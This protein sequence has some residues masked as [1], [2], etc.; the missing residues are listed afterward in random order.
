MPILGAGVG[1]GLVFGYTSAAASATAGQSTYQVVLVPQYLSA[2]LSAVT[3]PTAAPWNGSTGGILALDVA[4]TLTLNSATVSV[5]GMGFRGGAGMQLTGAAGAANTDYLFASPAAYTG[6]AGGVAGVDGSKG[7]GVAGTPEWVESSNTFLQTIAGVGY[8]S[9]TAGTDGSMAHG[10]PGNAGGGGTDSNPAANDQNAGGGGGG[11]GG[12]GGFGGDSWNMNLS[13]G[14]EGGS[15]F[16]GTIDRIALGGGGGAGSRNNSDS[17]NQASSG[18]AGGGMVFIRAFS[19][20]GTATITANG[21]NAYNATANDAGGGGGAGGTII[22][23]AASGGE[24]GLTLQAKGGTGGNAWATQPYSLADRHG[25]GGGGGGGVIF[26]SGAPASSSV[27]G[28]ADGLTLNPG[29]AYGATSGTAGTSATTANMS[30]VTG[31]QSAEVCTRLPDVTVVKSHV[32]NFTRGSTASYTLQVSNVNTVATSGVVTANDTVPLGLR[33]TSATG[34]GWTCSVSGQTVSCTR[35]DALAGGGSYPS[36]TVNVNVSQS[37]PATI[38]NTGAIGGG[39]D[40]SPLNDLTTDVAS[41]GSTADLSVTDAASP[42][43]VAAGGN[44]TYTQIVTDSGPSAAD[45]ATYVATIP[46]NTT[47]ASI[48]APAGWSCLSPG[49]G[50]TGNVVC[51]NVSMSALTA[52]TFSLVVK[53]NA[54]TAN[55]T[56]ITQTVSANSSAADPNSLNNTATAT[57]VVGTTAPDLTVTNVAS[58]NPV[59]AGNNITYT[60]VVTNTGTT[61]A[62]TATFTEATPANTTFFSITPP[63]GWTCLPAPPPVSCQNPSVAGGATGTFTVVYKVTAGTAGG[64]I[65]TDTVTVN[66]AN[67]SFGSNSATATDVVATAAQADLALT[68]AGAPAAVFSGN[69]ITYTQ[70]VTNNGPGAAT[71]AQFTEPIPA[72]TTFS[73]VIAPAGWTCTVTTSVTCTD[74]NSLA[75]GTS[76]DIIVVVNVA[77][78][79]AAGTITANSSVSATTTDPLASNNS[80]TTTTTVAPVCDLVVTNSGTPSPVAAGGTITYTQVITNSGPSNCSAGTFSEALPAN[81]TFVSVGV[82]TTGG[83]TWTCP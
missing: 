62:T 71:G 79:I 2:T 72:N 68:T 75:S 81:T 6:A 59:Q 33:P 76:A 53:V 61:A 50:G 19:F 17:D 77:P 83:G 35:S 14:G 74:G 7:E 65:I 43:P 40:I 12:A 52:A 60:Q 11:N 15:P 80:T 16:P 23:L 20:T 21:A 24:G 3:P 42:N 57:T 48:T 45:N 51:T 56:V 27:V 30:Q 29:V 8:P 73:S 49:I 44:I 41:V 55:G 1:G 13:S 54:G 9:G 22:M 69:N 26:V 34:T 58:P 66:A 38:T 28:G 82:V 31:L 64:T 5:N 4:N 39:G 78:S 63:A 18:A 10:A 67:Q 47:F 70:T 32:G 46:A 36:I 37:A 25:P